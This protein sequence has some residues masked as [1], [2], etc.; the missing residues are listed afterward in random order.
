MAKKIVCL[1]P[2]CDVQSHGSS[3]ESYRGGL[4]KERAASMADEGGVSGAVIDTLEQH[5]APIRQ[6]KQH[7]LATRELRKPSSWLGLLW[8]GAA[9]AAGTTLAI[10]LL[11]KRQQHSA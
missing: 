10:V 6:N 2:D 1:E 8:L 3:L 9:I 7:P 5:T 11:R 4:D